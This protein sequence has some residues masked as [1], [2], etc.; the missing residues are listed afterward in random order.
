M[1]DEPKPNLPP[2]LAATAPR[3]KPPGW[4]S[5]PGHEF[6]GSRDGVL[7]AVAAADFVP[8]KWRKRI[9]E[10]INELKPQFNHVTVNCHVS[11]HLSPDGRREQWT[12]DYDI[13]G[14]AK[15]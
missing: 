12:Y 15:L 10:D 14:C 1:A 3:A 9:A 4:W 2:K 13:T 7:K 6:D 5:L 8:E 11:I